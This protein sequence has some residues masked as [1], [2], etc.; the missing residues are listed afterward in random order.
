MK[1]SNLLLLALLLLLIFPQEVI[2]AEEE[3]SI[4]QLDS[5][6]YEKL[7]FKK[8]TDYLHD[9]KKVETKNTLPEKQ[10][11]L[12][13]DGSRQLPNRQ[14]TSSLFRTDERTEQ[15]TM[16][17]RAA[18]LKLFSERKSESP[19]EKLSQPTSSGTNNTLRTWIFIGIVVAGLLLLFVVMVPKL[20]QSRS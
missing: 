11:N 12:Y 13:F 5:I 6:L 20:S 9:K 15:S 4:D 18:E 2:Y 3:R 17:V 7:Q 14:D 19:K 16:A 8:N 1:R 10:L